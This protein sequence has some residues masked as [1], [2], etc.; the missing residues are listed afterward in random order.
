VFNGTLRWGGTE[1]ISRAKKSRGKRRAFWG[2]WVWPGEER[3]EEES[4]VRKSQET[5]APG[6]WF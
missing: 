1:K 3:L 2:N 5:T 6:V 4:S